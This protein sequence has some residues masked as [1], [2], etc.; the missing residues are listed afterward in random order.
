[1]CMSAEGEER[2]GGEAADL[3]SE[4]AKRCPDAGRAQPG[5][6]PGRKCLPG[7]MGWPWRALFPLSFCIRILSRHAPLSSGPRL[8]WTETTSKKVPC[9]PEPVVGLVFL[10]KALVSAWFF[11]SRP[12]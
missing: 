10:Q 4:V 5:R 3:A 6:G 12:V 2:G 9:Q 7:L 11:Q 1:M 8:L